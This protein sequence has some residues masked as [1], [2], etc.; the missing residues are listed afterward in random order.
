MSF[1]IGGSL[2][3]NK[4]DSSHILNNANRIENILRVKLGSQNEKEYYSKVKV[5]FNGTVKSYFILDGEEPVRHR[6]L[7]IKLWDGVETDIYA[8]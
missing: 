4:V 3:G 8:I 2:S 1:F 7:I 6:D 5:S